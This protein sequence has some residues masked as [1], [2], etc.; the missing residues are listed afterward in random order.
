MHNTAE[1]CVQSA[2]VNVV[3]CHKELNDPDFTQSELQ[4]AVVDS[5][6]KHSAEA[7]VI[8]QAQ[9]I[10]FY[11]LVPRSQTRGKRMRYTGRIYMKQV[12]FRS[13]VEA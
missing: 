11:S 7:A 2:L 10:R 6:D 13:A 9:Q 3:V 4:F 1:H 5:V 12:G 8:T